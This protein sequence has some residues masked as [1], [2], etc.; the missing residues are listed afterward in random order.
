LGT[1]PEGSRLNCLQLITKDVL[2]F[3]YRLSQMNLVW[4]NGFGSKHVTLENLLTK[5]AYMVSFLNCKRRKII[6]PHG[7]DMIYIQKSFHETFVD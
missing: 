7:V 5:F 6:L 1:L 3:A 4:R 2:L